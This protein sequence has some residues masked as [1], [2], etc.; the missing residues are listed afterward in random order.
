MSCAS[1]H[2]CP[3]APLPR[4]TDGLCLVP[5]LPIGCTSIDGLCLVPVPAG[6]GDFSR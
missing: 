3:G 1:C 2:H 4:R 6:T 5:A